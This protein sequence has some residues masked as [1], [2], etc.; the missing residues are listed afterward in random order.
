MKLPCVY[1]V[2]ALAMLVL[3]DSTG[4]VRIL[5]RIIN[6]VSIALVFISGQ[7]AISNLCFAGTE[8]WWDLKNFYRF[9]AATTAYQCNSEHTAFSQM[10][11]AR[12]QFTCT[13]NEMLA[14]D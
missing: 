9:Y 13:K 4:A 8:R 10:K 14:V 2:C 1:A 3:G 6:S 11:P 12:W 7:V 5:F